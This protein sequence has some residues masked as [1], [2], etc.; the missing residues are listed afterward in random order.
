M[1]IWSTASSL[2]AKTPEDRNRYVDFLRAVSI[3]FVITG[4]W[5]IATAVY[6]EG[7]FTPVD[8]LDH[9]PWTRW[10][11]WL[12]QVMPIFFIVGGYSNAVS[13]ESARRR[14]LAYA[15][16]LAARLHRLVSPVLVLLLGWA[17]IALVMRFVGV[18][19][20][21]IQFTSRAS[22]IPIWFL[23]IYIMVVILAPLTYG[24]WRRWGYGSA[25]MFGGVAVI[26]DL[27]F[28]EAGL[29]WLGWTNYFWIWLC[30]H[31]LGYAWRDNRLGSPSRMLL[32]S[33]LGLAALMVMIFAGPYP[34]AMAGSPGEGVS[35]T[36]PPKVTLIALGLM[37]FGLLMCIEAPMRRVLSGQ[38]LWT[39]TVLINSMIMTVYLWHITVMVVVVGLAYLAGGVGLTFEPGSGAW[40]L[41]RPVWLLVLYCL[42]L[43][44]ALALSALE[45]RPSPSGPEVPSAARQVAGAALICLG[46]AFLA[47]FGYGGGPLP[48]FDVMS[49]TLV[50]VGS[51]LSGLL[52]ASRPSG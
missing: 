4:H 12:F 9:R 50:I 25:A 15:Q 36:L 37:Q 29:E 46:I 27:L 52:F 41:A 31:Q 51:G 30:V 2:A 47:R 14:G 33:L 26:V 38:R 42:L 44:V 16:W 35:N 24:A 13:L 34:L 19:R 22:L 18:D 39:A 6:D 7:A 3:L 28:F 10:L 5:L 8:M 23:A 49:L 11:T 21:I 32:L 43:P 20:D 48:R 45:R 17:G 1:G 40:W